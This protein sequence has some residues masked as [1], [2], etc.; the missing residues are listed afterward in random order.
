[1][2]ITTSRVFVALEAAYEVMRAAFAPVK[3]P[4]T[5]R[6]VMVV[7]AGGAE[8]LL[9]LERVIVFSEPVDP[10]N[11]EPRT[12]GHVTYDETIRLR[13]RIEMGVPYPDPLEALRRLATLAG[14]A[15]T[16]LRDQHTGLPRALSDRDAANAIQRAGGPVRVEPKLAPIPEGW[17]AACDIDIDVI[18]R[19]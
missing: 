14:I 16:A 17:I 12:L 1:M 3:N 13:I 19:I 10:A 15:E 8:E 18:A 9:S 7:F 11:R 2:S 6:D 5:D 4:T